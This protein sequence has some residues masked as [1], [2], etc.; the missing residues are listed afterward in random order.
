M[1]RRD[2]LKIAAATGA[3]QASAQQALFWA[4]GAATP[5][6]PPPAFISNQASG[7][8]PSPKAL[9]YASNV[10]A[11]HMLIACILAENTTCST[12]T[13]SL[14]NTWVKATANTTFG[15]HSMEIW[16]ALN[17]IAGTETTT[18]TTVAGGGQVELML[19]EYSGIALTGAFD[20]TAFATGL[21]SG[22]VT[23]VFPHELLFG[24]YLATSATPPTA[25]SGYTTR[26]SFGHDLFYI[27]EDQDVTVTGSYAAV[28]VGGAGTQYT[29][30]AT[31]KA[32]F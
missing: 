12:V 26:N 16:Y 14:G 29:T 9:A 21:N 30:L 24:Y 18:V 4:S 8:G 22:S 20:Q 7:Q 5:S 2:L 17:S 27:N 32:Q 6:G 10:G 13:S 15:V 11:A 3:S 25:G 31:F 23:T 1:N 28:F 19:N